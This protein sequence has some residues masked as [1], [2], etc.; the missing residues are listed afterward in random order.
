M[1]NQQQD[2]KL[3]I[4]IWEYENAFGTTWNGEPIDAHNPTT[5]NILFQRL[6]SQKDSAYYYSLQEKWFELRNDKLIDS[7]S[8]NSWIDEHV[9]S[10]I[11]LSTAKN[12]KPF[13]NSTSLQSS[14]E[15]L[16]IYIGDRIKNL[17]GYFGYD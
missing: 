5:E 2:D 9:Q 1:Y 8:L 16:K 3:Q 11:K 4:T 12:S 15:E 7:S 10:T 13:Y 17:D 6:L 14:I